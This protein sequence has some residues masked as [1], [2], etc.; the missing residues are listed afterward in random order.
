MCVTG[1]LHAERDTASY[2]RGIKTGDREMKDLMKPHVT[3]HGLHDE[4]NYDVNRVRN[5]RVGVSINCKPYAP[6]RAA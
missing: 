3:P 2:P 1:G 6:R 5:A 4:W